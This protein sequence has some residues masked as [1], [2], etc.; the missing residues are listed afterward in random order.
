MWMVYVSTFCW[1][2]VKHQWKMLF[3]CQRHINIALYMISKIHLKIILGNHQ[4]NNVQ[5]QMLVK[6]A[7]LTL[8]SSGPY[9]WSSHSGT[10]MSLFLMS[11]NS[12]TTRSASSSRDSTQDSNPDLLQSPTHWVL[13][14][15]GFFI[16]TRSCEACWVDLAHQLSFY[17]D[18]PVL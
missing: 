9:G 8:T 1:S 10:A 2:S 13:G 12:G 16:W 11:A 17:L 14:F 7:V 15:I 18:S 4:Q 5:P 6:T 3:R